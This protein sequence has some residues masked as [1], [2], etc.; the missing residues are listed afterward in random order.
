MQTINYL[1]PVLQDIKEFKVIT[2][3][4]DVENAALSICID[5]LYKDQFITTTTAAIK[6]YEDMLGITAKG[7]DTLEDRRFRL[8]T[9]Y[10]KQLPYTKTVLE[11]N[12]TTFCGGNGYK[13]VIDY[14]NKVVIVKITLIAKTMFET[15]SAYL[16]GV[17]PMNL[18]IDLTLLYNQWIGLEKYTWAYLEQYTWEQLREEVLT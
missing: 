10:N 11:Q 3:C 8:L 14:A 2:S 13:L 7:T 15:V 5:N 17:I 16:D 12:L 1:P 18:A 4:I 6:R 9:L